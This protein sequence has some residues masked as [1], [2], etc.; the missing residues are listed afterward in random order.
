MKLTDQQI[1]YL[2]DFAR[3]NHAIHY[4]LQVEIVDHLASDIEQIWEKSPELSFGAV[5]DEAFV[6]FG[7]QGFLGIL[8]KKRRQLRVKYVKI[9]FSSIVEWF[10]WPRIM[11]FIGLFWLLNKGLQFEYGKY[12]VYAM[13]FKL[14]LTSLDLGD[15]YEKKT[16]YK[17]K[18]N[19]KKWM[20]E[21]MVFGFALVNCVFVYS[22]LFNFLL[23]RKMDDLDR[24]ILFLGEEFNAIIFTCIFMYLYIIISVLPKNIGQLLKKHYP[25]FKI[26]TNDY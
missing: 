1:D 21:E 25:E 10:Q 4:D 9:V 26:S 16:R 12:I 18:G 15:K 6:K 11:F 14:L 22:M 7:N 20:L 23:F 2:Y 8:R 17:V 3:D 5:I 19:K 24:F 13:I